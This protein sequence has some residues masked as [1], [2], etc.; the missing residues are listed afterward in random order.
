MSAGARS[1]ALALALVGCGGRGAPAGPVPRACP[2][3][4]VRVYGQSDLDG[5]RGCSHVGR[6]EVRT[7]ATLDLAPLTALAR[8]DGDLVVGPTLALAS[9]RLPALA[10]VV[11]AIRIQRNSDL[12]GVY[13]PALARTGALEVSDNLA[14]AQV[15][16]PSLREVTGD[17]RI[18]RAPS[19]ELIETA[20]GPRVLGALRVG[21]A[22]RLATW[23]GAPV[24]TGPVDL[25][26]PALDG[27]P[28]SAQP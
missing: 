17:V 8:V 18:E 27:G 28:T 2:T 11:G 12:Q 10:E 9:L 1:L 26:A 5:L 22:P 4:D 25:D 13:L 7:A 16:A 20:S 15:S 23:I 6:L 3:G 19:L 14:L 24:V 21:A